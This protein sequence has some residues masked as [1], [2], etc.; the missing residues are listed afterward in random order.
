MTFALFGVLTNV[1]A[2]ILPSSGGSF[3]KLSN[4]IKGALHLCG[5]DFFY[6]SIFYIGLLYNVQQSKFIIY[7]Q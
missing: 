7:F 6:S 4:M 1:A 2:T 3:A 5:E